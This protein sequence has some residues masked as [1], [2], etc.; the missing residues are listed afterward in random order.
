MAPFTD[1]RPELGWTQMV[2]SGP[3]WWER[4]M[5]LGQALGGVR[6]RPPGVQGPLSPTQL[7]WG[8]GKEGEARPEGVDSLLATPS[9]MTQ[10]PDTRPPKSTNFCGLFTTFP[11]RTW[12]SPAVHV[13]ASSA[14]SV[15]VHSRMRLWT[16]T[17]PPGSRVE[18]ASRLGT[19][20][21]CGRSGDVRQHPSL[22]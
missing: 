6:S 12:F 7:R 15:T 14:P 1:W 13:R 22:A 2:R 11:Q 18:D 4:Q 16:G 10:V 19:K 21:R 8:P 20:P 17:L 9:V 3:C 5:E